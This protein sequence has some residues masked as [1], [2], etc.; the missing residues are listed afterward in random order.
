MGLK[1]IRVVL[2]SVAPHTQ[3]IHGARHL[4]LSKL[5]HQIRHVLDVA[6]VAVAAVERRSLAV[7]L[8]LSALLLVKNSVLKFGTV[9]ESWPFLCAHTR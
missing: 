7:I 6:D 9:M 5:L 1:P 4:R 8:K 3:L 2:G